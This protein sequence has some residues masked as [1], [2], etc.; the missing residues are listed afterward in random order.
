[1]IEMVSFYFT[2]VR[3]I[4]GRRTAKRA[5]VWLAVGFGVALGGLVGGTAVASTKNLTCDKTECTW[6]ENLDGNGSDQKFDAM[7]ESGSVESGKCE[8]TGGDYYDCKGSTT[9]TLYTCDCGEAKFGDDS[10]ATIEVTCG[11]S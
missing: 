6:S 4:E 2:S 5:G 1:M 7:C 3:T 8:E 11:S 9:S 10:E